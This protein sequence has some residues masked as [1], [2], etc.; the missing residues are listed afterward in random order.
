MQMRKVIHDSARIG[1]GVLKGP[2]PEQRTAKAFRVKDGVG[3]LEIVSRISP[4]CK[5][6][7]PW[8]FFPSGN[9]GE[10]VHCGDAVFE[11]DFL[12]PASLKALKKMKGPDGLP[13]Y[14]P[15]QIDK[16][17]A[18]GPEKCNT[19]GYQ[20]KNPNQPDNKDNRFAVWHMTGTLSREDML[21]LQAPGAEELPDE[22]VE[23]FCIV[24]LV[25]DTVIRAIEDCPT[26][27]RD[28]ADETGLHYATVK[29]YVNA[30]HKEKLVRVVAWEK[31]AHGRDAARVFGWGTGPD[32]KRTR[33]SDAEKQRRYKVRL[34]SKQ[35]LHRMAGNYAMPGMQTA[36][37]C[38]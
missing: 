12:S 38:A 9:C 14:L 20:G 1:V 4:A 11:R 32:K 23:C 5:W 15:S 3:T 22:V 34:K 26:T 31:D 13:I 17:L 16:V 21:V 2:F 8:N 29:D 25:N 27:L 35:L 19:E 24:T 33:L 10:D 28:L 6:I 36:H 37:A 30:L 18:E 7:D